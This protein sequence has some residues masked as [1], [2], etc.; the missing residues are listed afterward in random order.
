MRYPGGI[1]SLLI[2]ILP[3]WSVSAQELSTY[4]APSED[5]WLEAY[6]LGEIS[7]TQYLCLTEIARNGIDSSSL[8][9]L[10]EIPNL[11]Y[12]EFPR[13]TL[14]TPLEQDQQH[15]VTSDPDLTERTAPVR[16]RFNYRY[17]QDFDD[18]SRTWYRSTSRVEL[19]DNF[20]AVWRINRESSGRER[21]VYRSVAW[22]GGNGLVQSAV[23]GNFTTRFGLGTLFGYRG[24]LMSASPHINHESLA[25][26]DYGGYNGLYLKARTQDI[27]S[28]MLV[29]IIRDQDHRLVSAGAMV[30]DQ[31]GRIRPG[32]IAG[33]NYLFDRQNRTAV[34]VPMLALHNE[35][36]Y[37]GGYGSVEI[38]GQFRGEGTLAAVVEGR[39]SLER[40]KLRYAG[41]AYG[42]SFYDLT[43]GSKTGSLYEEISL[44]EVNFECSS[45]RAGQKG[46]LVKTVVPLTSSVRC[47]NALLVA[48]RSRYHHTT[49]LSSALV[50][51]L[52]KRGSVQIDFLWRHR[53]RLSGHVVSKDHRGR[54]RLEG[55]FN[56]GDFRARSYIGYSTESERRDYL[57]FF[58]G[59][60]FNLGTDGLFR[61]WSNLHKFGA[62]GIEYWYMFVQ[63]EQTL[64]ENLKARVKL[65]HTYRG[66]SSR[67]HAT[68]FSLGVVADL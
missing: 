30:K 3:L 63:S 60:R 44:E 4:V 51:S 33:V 22:D 34:T 2:L 67:R 25:Y 24:K 12:F 31:S 46:A 26:P 43:S 41:W 32:L 48:H 38:A 68:T 16:G 17:L 11:S 57:S 15:T 56:S 49:Q 47:A 10:D 36:R 45:K 59:M 28:Q 29:S 50:R 1:L 37:T 54:W 13:E 40:V 42:D 18:E 7:Y 27:E 64:L 9:L 55:R 20:S 62:G 6:E 39:H 52:G 21:I 61:V 23:I 66:E 35:Y 19:L 53:S 65:A 14:T 5:E 8:Y 58:A